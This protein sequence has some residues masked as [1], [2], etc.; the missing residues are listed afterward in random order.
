MT[1]EAKPVSQMA[2]N[3]FQGSQRFSVMAALRRM[4]MPKPYLDVPSTLL[5]DVFLWFRSKKEPRRSPIAV[6]PSSVPSDNEAL[7]EGME[8]ARQERAALAMQ[9]A[10]R[11]YP[12]RM[13]ALNQL[14][15]GLMIP[16]KTHSQNANMFPHM[17]KPQTPQ[18]PGY[19]FSQIAA[20]YNNRGGRR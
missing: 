1:V 7:A 19:D 11:E 10:W 3:T 15:P 5:A 8:L 4:G 16:G 17:Q 2:R 9:R 18:A 20:M 12:E 13:Q 14:I 6:A